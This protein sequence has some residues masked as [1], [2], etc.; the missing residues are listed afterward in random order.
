MSFREFLGFRPTYELH[1]VHAELTDPDGFEMSLLRAANTKYLKETLLTVA[2]DEEERISIER[3]SN[4]A[5]FVHGPQLREDGVT[6]HFNHVARMALRTAKERET[7]PS[8]TLLDILT[9]L[10]HDTEE[11]APD[12]HP[13]TQAQFKEGFDIY[14]ADE[15]LREKLYRNIHAMN[16]FNPDR[17]RKK[18]PD[19][20]ITARGLWPRK[21]GDRG[22]CL[23]GDIMLSQ[24][25]GRSKQS[26]E[27]IKK[28]LRK[29]EA[30]FPHLLKHAPATLVKLHELTDYA[31][32]YIGDKLPTRPKNYP[33]R[34]SKV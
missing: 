34:L 26:L 15:P 33:P 9:D 12:Y 5:E 14:F 25:R 31:H 4:F 23:K 8:V 22:D 19:N 3:A 2:Q 28:S 20:D 18:D 11:D 27:R 16:K 1:P 21:S 17:T 32:L 10:L 30:I 24:K 6:P 7:D 29:T 13:I